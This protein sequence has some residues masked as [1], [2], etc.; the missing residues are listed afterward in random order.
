[1]ENINIEHVQRLT[2]MMIMHNKY[3]I[4]TLEEN[5]DHLDH[6]TLLCFQVLTAEFCVQYIL[7]LDIESGNEDSYIFDK[8]YIMNKQLHITDDDWNKAYKKFYVDNK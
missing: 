1:M 5:I 4:K 6:K 3:D 2:D 8:I 7:D